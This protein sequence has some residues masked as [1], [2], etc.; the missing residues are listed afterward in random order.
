VALSFTLSMCKS[1]SYLDGKLFNGAVPA[2]LE[3]YHDSTYFH[4]LY[5]TSNGDNAE[6]N[7]KA[8]NLSNPDNFLPL[9]A[10]YAL[11]TEVRQ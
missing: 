11:N 4:A 10:A 1:I 8:K 2:H 6:S 9:V 7:R 5:T 3:M